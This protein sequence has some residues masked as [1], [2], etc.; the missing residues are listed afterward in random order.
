MLTK[1]ERDEIQLHIKH[2]NDNANAVT[3]RIVTAVIV[4]LITAVVIDQCYLYFT[5]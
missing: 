2:L 3:E 5:K 4:A 1:D